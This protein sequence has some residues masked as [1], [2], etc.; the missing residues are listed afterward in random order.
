MA[1]LLA[2]CSSNGSRA[3]VVDRGDGRSSVPQVTSGQYRVKRGDTLF[4]IAS[5]NGWEWRALAAQNGLG[6]PY[7][8]HVG[9]VIR[10]GS[11][12]SASGSS[13]IIRR[14]ATVASAPAP[15]TPVA[16]PVPIPPPVTSS[17]TVATP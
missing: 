11:G 17:P 3:P 4:S 1:L 10:F 8:I 16:T 6:A 13:R 14:P 12:S 5:R 7:V 15:G 9:Q 2:G